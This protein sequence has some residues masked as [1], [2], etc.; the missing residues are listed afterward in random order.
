ML[1]GPG[2]ALARRIEAHLTVHVNV[3]CVLGR[4][5]SSEKLLF[6]TQQVQ[7]KAGHF[8]DLL[9]VFCFRRYH[10]LLVFGLSHHLVPEIGI[11]NLGNIT[12]IIKD[13]LCFIQDCL[14]FVLI[15]KCFFKIHIRSPRSWLLFCDNCSDVFLFCH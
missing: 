14:E 1:E 10:D 3:Q 11:L 13:A 6:F 7:E 12:V 4:A 15:A 9:I 8:C 2:N 5:D